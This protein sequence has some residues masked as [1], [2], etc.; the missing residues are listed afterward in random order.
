MKFPLWRRQQRLEQLDEEIQSHLEMAARDR[1]DRGENP[2]KAE[3][4]ARRELGN[5]DLIKGVTRE[6]WG[7]TSLELLLGDVRYGLRMLLRAPGFTTVAVLTLALGIGANT[8]LFSIINGVLL[9]PLLFPQPDQLVMVHESK[10]NFDR[11]SISYPNFRDWQKENHTLSSLA[12][13]RSTTFSLTGTG[14]AEQVNAQFIS[15]D[16]FSLLGVKPV[17]GRVLAPEEDQVGAAAV[18]LIS[19][20]M[21]KRKFGAAAAVLGKSITLDGKDYTIVGVIPAS[22]HLLTS[23]FSTSE[24]YVPIGQWTNNLLLNRGAGL[25]IHGIGR[26]KPGVAIEQAQAD[27]DGVT[28]N[29]AA[30]YPDD[31][32]GIGAKLLPL[33]SAMVGRIHPMLFVLLGAVGFVLLIACVNVA[34]LLLARS[35]GRTREFAVRSALGASQGRLVRQLLTESILLAL[36]GGGLGLLV[37]SWGTRAAL[38][39]LPSALPRAEEISLDARVL[40]FTAAISLLGGILFGLVPALKTLQPNLFE[41]L[42]EGGRG[43]SGARHRTQGVFVL[44]EMALALVLLTGAGLMI[45]S[46]AALWS[47][48]LGFRSEN[49]LTFSLGLLPSSTS[50]SPDA[51]RANLREI[52]RELVSTRGI[53]AV[54]LLWG[55]FPLSGDDEMVF[56]L[57]GQSQPSS[58]SEMNWALKYVVEADYLKA[59]RIPL[60]RGRFFT[61]QDDEHSPLVVVVDDA[62]ARKFFGSADPIGKRIVFSRTPDSDPEKAEIVGVV[63]HVKQWG[64]DTDSRWSLQ[65]QLYIPFMQLG[66][67]V[68]GMVSTGVGVVVRSDGATPAVYDSV[69]DALH[70]MNSQQVAFGAQTMDEIISDS[71]ATRRFSMILLGVFAAVALL[72]SSVGIYGVISYGVGQ[73][74][75]EI[76]IRLALGARRADVLRLVL[77]EGARLALAGVAVGI[78]AALGLTRLMSNMLYG[79]SATDPLTFAGVAIVLTLVALAACYIPARRAMRVDPIVA[80]RY[81]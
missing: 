77:G 66:D 75:H 67:R 52:D 30:A 41:T 53:Q 69:R 60:Q 72:L 17:I 49:I 46:L 51:V 26:L 11:G 50:E 14:E 20:G 62:F 45:R 25:G 81:E 2:K 19:E 56:W 74:T 34:N 15:S 6:M 35:T 8:A 32:K 65:A 33:K 18:A 4:S 12:I 22:F 39:A 57:D 63:G 64:I 24:I 58:Q 23:T 78:L 80:L 54:S 47:V 31:D 70:R 76:G 79:V 5:V 3:E 27:M 7:W 48:N 36:G 38:G 71:L 21:W 55:A 68:M 40:I 1:M 13:F 59:M 37:A 61:P 43:A 16:F 44:V 9:N 42:K 10:P 28:R 73:R 29:L